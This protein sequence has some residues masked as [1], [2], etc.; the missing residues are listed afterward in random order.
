MRAF[1]RHSAATRRVV[2]DVNNFGE[3]V[4]VVFE[5]LRRAGGP[6]GRQIRT[7]L[8]SGR[9]PRL[10]GEADHRVFPVPFLR[11][12]LPARGRARGR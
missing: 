2:L 5:Q 6:L 12:R 11:L 10:P 1:A 3:V 7:G 4:E 9:E 8:L